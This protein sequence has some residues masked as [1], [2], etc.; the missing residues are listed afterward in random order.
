[1]LE[2]FDMPDTHEACARRE[3]TTT[4]PQALALLNSQ[5]TV[6]WAKSFAGRVVNEAGADRA[7]QVDEAYRLAYSRQP[8]SWEKDTALT[9]FEKQREVISER[10]KAGEPIATPEHLPAGMSR[11]DGAALVDF[12]HSLF[13]SNEFVY[14]N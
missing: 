6:E 14:R 2:S 12:C 13:N 11:E 8:D 5:H 9:F 4:A 3:M 10:D 1:M 7:S